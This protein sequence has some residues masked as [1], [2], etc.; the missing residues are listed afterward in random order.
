MGRGIH[1]RGFF[2]WRLNLM[3]DPCT[4]GSKPAPGF[5]KSR[6]S[7]R[8]IERLCFICAL[9]KSAASP[10]EP[11][12]GR[13]HPS[14]I[15]RKRLPFHRVNRFTQLDGQ[16]ASATCPDWRRQWRLP[17]TDLHISYSEESRRDLHGK[18]SLIQARRATTP[19]R[20][21]HQRGGIHAADGE[22]TEKGKEM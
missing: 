14:G 10:R 18:T 11:S 8:F 20:P 3:P 1:L 2:D 7:L 22:E 21:G 19:A 13:I 6:W 9:S 12:P 5:S 15:V 16:D 4:F 17:T